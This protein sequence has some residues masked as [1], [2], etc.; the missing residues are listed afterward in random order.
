[1]CVWGGGVIRNQRESPPGFPLLSGG[2]PGG[3]FCVIWNASPCSL[4]SLC[5]KPPGFPPLCGGNPGGFFALYRTRALIAYPVYP[6]NNHPF[7]K[8]QV[9]ITNKMGWVYMWNSLPLGLKATKNIQNGRPILKAAAATFS[10]QILSKSKSDYNH[11]ALPRP[12][13]GDCRTRPL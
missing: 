12:A 8:F 5:K 7:Q 4:C 10:S 9:A 6:T 13:P 2:N 1:M 11:P 3:F